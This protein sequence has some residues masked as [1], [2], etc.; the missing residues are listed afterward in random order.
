MAWIRQVIIGGYYN[1]LNSSTT[2][3]NEINGGSSWSSSESSNEI[4]VPLSGT[5]KHFAVTIKSAPGSGKSYAF[6]VRK[7]NADTDLT[8]TVSDTSTTATDLQNS[9]SVSAGDKICLK[10]TPSNTPSAQ[11]CSWGVVFEGETADQSMV[12]GNLFCSNN[13][14]T[15]YSGLLGLVQST[16]QG[17]YKQII[18]TAGTLKNLYVEL[19][20]APGDTKSRAFT[21]YKNGVA[22]SLTCTVSDTNTTANDLSNTV[23]VSAGDDVEFS[24]AGSN[25]PATG[26]VKYGMVFQADTNFESIYLGCSS[27][28]MGT[29]YNEFCMPNTGKS[30]WG[31]TFYQ[32]TTLLN[33]YKKLYVE[34]ETAPGAGE[35]YTLNLR[36]NNINTAVS[37]SISDTSTTGNNTAD[38]ASM[39]NGDLITLRELPS[40]S[41]VT[42]KA[43]WGFVGVSQYNP[44]SNNL[45]NA[46]IL[47]KKFNEN[48][49]NA[50]IQTTQTYS[51]ELLLNARISVPKSSENLL[52][53][54]I[55][56]NYSSD[57]LVS[58]RI[59]SIKYSN[60]LLNS[61]VKL[62]SNNS[63]NLVSSRIKIKYVSDL[64][65][66][67][68]IQKE[69]FSDNLLNAKLS[70]IFASL[71]S[72]NA[73]IKLLNESNEVLLNAKTILHT[74]SQKLISS[75]IQKEFN[76]ENQ[77]Q[78]RIKSEIESENLLLSRIKNEF[79][80]L[81]LISAR[82]KQ[83]FTS[84]KSLN[85]RVKNSFNSSNLLNAKIKMSY[86]NEVLLN[87]TIEALGYSSNLCN[88]YIFLGYQSD[89]VCNA[90]IIF[91]PKIKRMQDVI[92][93]ETRS[94]DKTTNEEPARIG[95]D[96]IFPTG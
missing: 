50:K 6:T 54:R 62:L 29:S 96:R 64:V 38:T 86:S 59:K 31:I 22:T 95:G 94:Y 51:N 91:N 13:D 33:T 34:L 81:N 61:R 41:P 48:L 88:A 69:N 21:V 89:L 24:F 30:D 12:T 40:D 55:Q 45:I 37:F 71:N 77:L 72:A 74:F 11:A 19:S 67:A 57:N 42:G 73:R 15:Y 90:R 63:E 78:A 70:G 3:Y 93:S 26:Y 17:T 25:T 5:I 27:D 8:C 10:A 4:I 46:R 68:R 53:S 85:S 7:N 65:S 87:S 49:L 28:D 75:R 20:I 44:S 56:K 92:G 66:S 76:K 83:E 9:F 2:E 18:P 1:S 80:S 79:N 23:S 16:T 84:E 35:S 52:I 14:T 47:I 60:N 39:S 82:I 36:K 43:Y 58:S 32:Q